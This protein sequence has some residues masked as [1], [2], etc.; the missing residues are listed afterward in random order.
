MGV[1]DSVANLEEGGEETLEGEQLG[2]ISGA[3][4]VKVSEGVEQ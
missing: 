1:G 3:I 2:G 4:A